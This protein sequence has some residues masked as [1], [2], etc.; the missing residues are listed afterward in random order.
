MGQTKQI[1]IFIASS[2]VEFEKDRLELM[3]HIAQLN[4]SYERRG[5]RFELVGCENMSNALATGRKQDEYNDEIR[6]CRYVY[7]LVGERM[8]GYTEEEFDVALDQF[9]RTGVQPRIY[10]Y[11]KDLPEGA[12][13]GSVAAFMERLDRQLGHFYSVYS[14]LDSVKLNM[15]M[16]L[17]RDPDV[18]GVVEFED[19]RAVLNG[20]DMMS[21]ENVPMYGGNDGLQAMRVELENLNERFAELKLAFAESGEMSLFAEMKEVDDKR[22]ELS[23]QVKKMENAILENMNLIASM[24]RSAES[25]N[26]RERKAAA[27]VESGK[28]KE[29]NMYLDDPMWDEEARQAEAVA[30][31]ARSQIREYV[32]GQRAYVTNLLSLGAIAESEEKILAAYERAARLAIEWHVCLDL[33]LDYMSF[34]ETQRCYDKGI[35]VGERLVALCSAYEANPEKKVEAQLVLAKMR[36]RQKDFEKANRL[37]SDAIADLTALSEE[38]GRLEPR[39]AHAHTSAGESLWSQHRYQEAFDHLQ[40]AL[41]MQLQRPDPSDKDLGYTYNMLGLVLRALGDYEQSEE[42]QVKAIE[43]RAEAARDGNSS[44]I[45]SLTI[46]WGNMAFLLNLMGRHDEAERY[47]RLAIEAREKLA[48]E[49][50]TAYEPSVALTKTNYSRLLRA[51]GRL[52]EA[53]QCLSEALGIRRKFY[54]VDPKAYQGSMA[55]ALSEYGIL[56]R[57]AGWEDRFGEAVQMFE[58]SLE[59]RHRLAEANP[60]TYGVKC[61]ESRC[62][63]AK[64]LVLMGESDKA[65]RQFSTA[66]EEIE[67]GLEKGDVTAEKALAKVSEEFARA[68][69]ANGKPEEAAGLIGPSGL[70]SR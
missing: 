19:G 55:I 44:R 6:E 9:E 43:H 4:R 49:N 10:T 12:A 66:I 1:K 35:E 26:W 2:I 59:I 5:I 40:R 7:V 41:E 22:N 48:Q 24:N 32:S 67:C 23:D 16:E 25:V 58:E 65:E 18:G 50:P 17:M 29:A 56:I 14:D 46:S 57:D 30:G 31:G 3:N 21:L 33:L 63:Y 13:D 68:L 42:Y 38:S 11:F 39:L 34:L 69:E 27:L 61:G 20:Q 15:I 47:F 51:T 36:L 53:D 60:Q 45:I 37:Y 70:L 54:E 28:Y 8:G 62:E 52:D 64:L